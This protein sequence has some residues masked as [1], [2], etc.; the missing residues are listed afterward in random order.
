[1]NKKRAS[2]DLNDDIDIS[3]ITSKKFKRKFDSEKKIIESIAEKSGF[4]SREPKKR[5]SKPKSPFIV[6]M[7]I[8]TRYGAKELF[9]ETSDKMGCFDHTTFEEA[10]IA[11]L[12][13]QGFYNILDKYKK[14]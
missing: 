3:E 10:F 4:V 7:N 12:E 8:K 5:K 6:Q 2:L 13:K 1:M 9:Q 11:L 14:L